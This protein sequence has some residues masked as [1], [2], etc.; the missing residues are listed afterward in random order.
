MKKFL[1]LVGILAG[2]AVIAI[3]VMITL[4]PWMD[5]WGAREGE[6]AES[7]PGDQLV[8]SPRVFYNRAVT[9]NASPQEIYPWIVQLG[10]ERGGMYSYEWF[11]THVLQCE[12]INA[13]RIHPEWQR[14]KVGDKVKMCPGDWGPPA[15]EVA[16][17]E[18]N[19][20]VVLGHQEHGQWSDVWQFVLLP[21][22]DGTTRMILRSRDVKSGLFWDVMRPGEFIMSRGMLLGIK[23]RAELL[24]VTR[25]TSLVLE[26]VHLD[27]VSAVLDKSFPPGCIEDVSLCIQA[28]DEHNILSVTFQPRD[29]PEEQMLAY[30]MLPE[31]YVAMEGGVSASYSL[32][33]YDNLSHALTIGFEVPESATT[34]GLHWADLM[35]IPLEVVSSIT[36]L[37]TVTVSAFRQNISLAYDQA[38]APTVE[39]AI[40]SAVPVSD[41]ILFA[42]AHPTYAQIRFGCF[43]W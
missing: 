26:G 10:A 39:T 4:M 14:L 3:V 12:L 11:E 1:K 2:L 35:E 15:Y 27:I 28:K 40:L 9:V 32:H 25:N 21:Q 7:F 13:D 41:Q 29:L 34:F 22:L 24:A 31:V 6:V 30:K 5:S 23:E 16:L 20:A 37:Q 38:L 36:Q 18:P 43:G 33:K 19:H 42:E 17:L 8:P